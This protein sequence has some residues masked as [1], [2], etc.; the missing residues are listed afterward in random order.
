MILLEYLNILIFSSAISSVNF[1]VD[2]EFR[3]SG[4]GKIWRSAIIFLASST[5]YA[6]S[7]N[8]H[9]FMQNLFIFCYVSD[10]CAL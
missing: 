4:S 2:V 8:T 6:Q 9:L 1:N 7:L 5:R 3:T 10:L